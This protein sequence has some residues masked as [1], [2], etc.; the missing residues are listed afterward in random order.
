MRTK[1]NL[2]NGKV[3]TSEPFIAATDCIAKSSNATLLYAS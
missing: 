3:S 2:V 1:A